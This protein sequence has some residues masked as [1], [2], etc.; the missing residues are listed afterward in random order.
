M[1]GFYPIDAIRRALAERARR[2][3]VQLAAGW[4]QATAHINGW[5][6]LPAGNAAKSFTQ[7][8]FIEARFHFLLNGEYYGGYARSVAM[9]RREAEKLAVG[10][11]GVIVRYNPANPDEAVVL[12]EDNAGKLPFEVVSG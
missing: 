11:P 5:K 8:D 3:R 12:A 6:V 4:P 7:T 9:G 1:A 10:E 2:K